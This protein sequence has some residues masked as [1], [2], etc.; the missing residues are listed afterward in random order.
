MRQVITAKPSGSSTWN[1]HTGTPSVMARPASRSSRTE[2]DAAAGEQAGHRRTD[3]SGDGLGAD[4]QGPGRQQRAG[5]QRQQAIV[6][7]GERAA[8]QRH[9]EREVL[10][11]GG[12]AGDAGIEPA[13]H[14][15]DDRQQRQ[16]GE[17]Q[18]R[19]RVFEPLQGTV[20]VDA[21]GFRG[22]VGVDGHLA[23]W[24]LRNASRSRSPW[25]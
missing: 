11:E 7:G 8:E 25:S 9:H 24:L 10:D 22:G 13:Q 6:T 17:C 4:V 12:A 23:P 16:D 19:Q 2:I 18:H 3:E 14:D 21:P 5:G 1:A 15:L 20:V